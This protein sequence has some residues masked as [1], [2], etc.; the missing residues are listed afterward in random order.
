MNSITLFKAIVGS[1]AYGT[2]M[3]D[4]DIDT[5]G[6]YLQDPMEILGID[7]KEQINVDKDN[8]L[9]E[10]RRF[11]QLLSTGNPTMLELLFIPED[12]I[13]EKHPLWDIILQ[14]RNAFLTKQCYNSFAGYA[15]Q[16]IEKAKGLNKKMNWEA[17]RVQRKRPID[18]L[19]VIDGCKT[20]PLTK[21]LKRKGMHEDCCGLSKVNDSENIYALWYDHIKDISKDVDLTNPRY[22]DWKDFGYK[23]VC[24]DVNLLLSEIP[25][26]QMP[27]CQCIL[28][29]NRNGWSEHCKDYNSYQT[30]L[31]ERNERRYVDVR[32]HGQ[33]IDGKNMM[34][35]VRLLQT[36]QDIIE[37][38][39]INVRVENPEYYLS[40][41]QGKVPLE[42]L[43]ETSKQK[44]EKLKESFKT[45]DLPDSVNTELVRHIL[46]E[47]RKE[48]LKLF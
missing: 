27:M 5:K 45:S 40:I 32:G 15:Y 25:E 22:K 48:S 37:K 12:C 21:W 23:G 6:V 41:R 14:H 19:K 35:C 38:H 2:N 34:H 36:A 28:Y 33:K 16:Q 46:Y 1:Q 20:Y 11:L 43:I 30:W 8:C 26:W 17:D 31:R 24:D 39:T 10:V 4:S 29:F 47:L 13:L 3:P 42:S 18:F 44:I 9:Y 7:Y